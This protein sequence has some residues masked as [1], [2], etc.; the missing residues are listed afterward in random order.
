MLRILRRNQ[1]DSNPEFRVG[2]GSDH[3]QALFPMP[4]TDNPSFSA[5]TPAQVQ[6][7]AAA[8]RVAI[9]YLDPSQPWYYGRPLMK[10]RQSIPDL[11]ATVCPGADHD[12]G[13][14]SQFHRPGWTGWAIGTYH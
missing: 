10:I 12:P 7:G 13:D 2:L 11:L 5:P 3:L 14:G 1:I 9:D 4:V 8:N 6:F